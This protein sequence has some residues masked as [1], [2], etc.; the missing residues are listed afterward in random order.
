MHRNDVSNIVGNL[1]FNY[2]G[3]KCFTFKTKTVCA[4]RAWWGKCNRYHNVLTAETRDAL[5]YE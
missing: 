5:L 3:M 1:Y 2:I 4:E